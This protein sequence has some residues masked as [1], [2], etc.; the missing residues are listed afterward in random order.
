[1]AQPTPEAIEPGRLVDLALA[2]IHG[3]DENRETENRRAAE[4]GPAARLSLFQLPCARAQSA[5]G[6]MLTATGST[7]NF[8][9]AL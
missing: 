6:W 7:Q 3:G 9:S 8:W 1:M 5:L 2:V 4:F